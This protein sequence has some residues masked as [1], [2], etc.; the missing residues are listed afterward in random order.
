MRH[1][2]VVTKSAY[3]TCNGWGCLLIP[4]FYEQVGKQVPEFLEAK[5]A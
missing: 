1:V 3:Y 4:D 2:K 5:M